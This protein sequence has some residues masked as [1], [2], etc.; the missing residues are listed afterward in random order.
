MR[1]RALA[2]PA[3]VGV[4]AVGG[5]LAVAAADPQTPGGLIPV[6]PTKALFGFDCPGCGSMRMVQALVQGDLGAAVAFNALGVVAIL[7]LLWSYATWVGDRLGF[8]VRTWTHWRYAPHTVGV[9]TVAWFLLRLLIP[10]MR[11]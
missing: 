11:P 6:C 1:W 9:V 10:G 3:M 2:A 5:C 8:R 7:L 4:A